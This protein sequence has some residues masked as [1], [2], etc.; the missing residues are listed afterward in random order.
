MEQAELP[1]KFVAA[2]RDVEART[3]SGEIEP[4]SAERIMAVIWDVARRG[5]FA[6]EL[7]LRLAF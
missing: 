2:I 1:I 5:G 7:A 3:A 6:E 4:A